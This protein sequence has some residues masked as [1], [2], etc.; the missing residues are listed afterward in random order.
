MVFLL[1]PNLTQKLFSIMS[2]NPD[3]VLKKQSDS[4]DLDALAALRD[5]MQAYLDGDQD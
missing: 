5:D 1:Y 2:K 4:F 3:T